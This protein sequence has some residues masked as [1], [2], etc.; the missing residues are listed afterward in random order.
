MYTRFP[1]NTAI[2]LLGGRTRLTRPHAIYLRS[3]DIS[4]MG[5]AARLCYH[6]VPRMMKGTWDGETARH[7]WKTRMQQQEQEREH[8]TKAGQEKEKEKEKDKENQESKEQNTTIAFT[9]TSTSPLD[10]LPVLSDHELQCVLEYLSVSRINMNIRQV[11]MQHLKSC[12]HDMTFHV[13]LLCPI[14]HLLHFDL[15]VA[16][17]VDM[18]C[19]YAAVLYLVR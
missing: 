14:E 1:G 13:G 6:G 18:I 11:C 5:N 7:V 10:P 19:L 16:C 9:S 4:I 2:F 12:H 15:M 8:K 17:I 3:G